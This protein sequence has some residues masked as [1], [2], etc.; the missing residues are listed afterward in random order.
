M[1]IWSMTIFMLTYA[2]FMIQLSLIFS[3]KELEMKKVTTLSIV[4]FAIIFS[5]FAQN[6]EVRKLESFTE[7]SVGEAISVTLIPGDKNEASILV[8]NIALEDISTKVYGSKL[9]IELSGNHHRNIDVE[10]TLTYKEIERLSVTSAANVKT[11]GAI[12]SKE[13]DITVSSAGYA[14]LEIVSEAL[15]VSVSSSG[16]LELNGKSLSQRVGVSSAGEYN[17]YDLDFDESYVKAS[18]AGSARVTANKKIEAKASSAGSVKY[19]GNPDKVYVNA[20]SGGSTSKS[21]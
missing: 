14:R 11:Q 9:K 1:H 13:L 10:I 18:S 3:T 5:G 15:E 21:N 6:R 8:D 19:K 12:R 20:S 4:F 7:L 17:G 2:T 16:E